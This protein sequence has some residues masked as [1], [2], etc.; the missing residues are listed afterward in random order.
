MWTE[1]NTAAFG[2][3]TYALGIDAG[4]TYTDAA[5]VDLFD[6]RVA[7][8]A[9][10]PTNVRDP[11][12]SIRR[13]LFKLPREMVRSLEFVSLA[14]T[15]ATNAIVEGRGGRAGLI[16]IGYDRDL[17]GLSGMS[18][19]LHVDGGH[20]FW[21]EERTP[22]DIE[23]L[24]PRLDQ[25]SEGLEAVAISGFFS[26]R[27]P[28]HEQRVEQMV[29]ERCGLPTVCG[30]R[31]SAR[32]DAP[33][34]AATAWWNGRLIS[35]LSRLID[36]A[37]SVLAAFEIDAPLMVVRGDGALMSADTAK[38]RPVETLVSGPAASIL[39]ARHLTGLDNGLVVDIGGTT[40]DM[41][42]LV[43]GKVDIDPD[44][45]HIGGWKTHVEAARIRTAGLGGDSIID[46]ADGRI[47]SI[48]I[49]PDRVEPLCVFADR[50]PEMLSVLE[51]LAGAR[52]GIPI[53][54]ANPCT[55]YGRP[56][57]GRTGGEDLPPN[58][59]RKPVNEYLI[60]DDPASKVTPWDL[61][62][63]AREGRLIRASLTPTDFR[64]ADGSHK[65]GSRAGARLGVAV[66][67]RA[68]G[69]SESNLY[70]AVTDAVGRRL[71]GQAVR[72]LTGDDAQALENLMHRWFSPAVDRQN[73][74]P[75]LQLTA[76]ITQP[77]IGIGAP[78]EA[79][80][81]RAFDHLHA[82][83]IL[84]EQY[85]VGTA[86]GAVVGTVGFTLTAEVR[87]AGTD[88]FVLYSPRKK[89]EFED[90]E[91]ATAAGRADLESLALG[92]LRADHVDQPQLSFSSERKSVPIPGGELYLY[93][94]LRLRAA[95]RMN[96]AGR[97]S[98]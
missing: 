95:G 40:T 55:F 82:R 93:T 86:V 22:L 39:G 83:C 57:D 90:F 70:R 29:R 15:F 20:D 91:S 80:L 43:N 6:G 25:F 49:G 96:V 17:P 48:T 63:R 21:G 27:N 42:T 69:V 54:R 33:K 75:G 11:I 38:H 1:P 71:C 50:H 14:T 51:T 60:T 97:R 32:I 64:V 34:R 2:R 35:L 47:E 53:R 44:G 41:A 81:P 8:F 58:M 85:T 88:R 72:H 28:D 92:R 62:S 16:L 46:T 13:V 89:T 76:T 74:G 30:H 3:P 73:P 19:I 10:A 68:L 37:Q 36:A 5:I 87:P 7:G 65:L 52:S 78:A 12:Q 79:W 61:K 84:P 18:P 9:K 66:F 4:G 45:A 59:A 67:A 56:E 94:L 26:V 23:G 24:G 98:S 77:V 31:L